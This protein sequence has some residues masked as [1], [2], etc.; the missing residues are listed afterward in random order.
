MDKQKRENIG[1]SLLFIVSLF[2]IFIVCD[3]LWRAQLFPESWR[4]FY[5][6]IYEIGKKNL[7]VFKASYLVIIALMAYSNPRMQA[8]VEKKLVNKL[9]LVAIAVISGAIFMLGYIKGETYYN[10]IVYP[11]AFITVTYALHEAVQAIDK[12]LVENSAV[13]AD[14]ST[15]NGKTVP[16]VFGTD[17]GLLAVPDPTLGFYF[18]GTAGSGKSV[19]IENLLHQA[20][21]KGYAGVVYDYEGNPLEEDGAVLTRLV[22]TA[23]KNAHNTKTRFAFLNCSDLTKSVRCN[24]LSPKYLK[25]E[26]DFIS[27]GNTLMKNLEKEWVEKTD[28]WASNAINIVVGSALKM[29]KSNP[30]FCTI[31]HLVSFIL[32]DFRAVLNY[33]ATDKELEP[34][35]MPVMS[36]YK[37]QANQQTAGVISSSQLPLTKLFTPEIFWVFAPPESEEFSLD[38][39]NK[40]DPVFFCIGNNPKQKAALSPVIALVLSTC[41]EQMNQFDRVK[42]LFVVD[43]LPTIYIPNLDTLPATARK[44]G[45]ITTLTVQTFEQLVQANGKVN[46]TI[47]RDNL[48]NQFVGKTNSFDTAERIAKLFGEYKKTETSYTFS[49]SGE[50]QTQSSKNERFLQ[51]KDVAQQRTGHWTGFVANG[52]PPFFHAQF[53]YFK[54]DKLSIPPF[55]QRVNSG[56]AQLDRETMDKLVRD[57]F[58]KIRKDITDL[59]A[60]YMPIDEDTD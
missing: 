42:S 31:P 40:K 32:S 22:Y 46:A 41:M 12:P 57:N 54:V 27:A 47:I 18:E 56:D 10:L 48:S 44:K 13:L 7:S 23:L 52:N 3:W 26:L 6:P 59:L 49:E 30:Q 35:I 28:F 43:E 34:W 39:T 24:P 1:A 50:S 58:N 20:A 33:L 14:V 5:S 17:K 19:M 60:P 11:I 29:R 25:T 55:A 21:Q 4:N 53:D 9:V 15:A 36:A 38:I 37:Q 16:F 51:P 45:V 8:N 2:F